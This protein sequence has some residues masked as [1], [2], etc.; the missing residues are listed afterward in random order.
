MATELDGANYS[1]VDASNNNA[2]PNGMPEGMSPSGVNDAGRQLMGAVK[3]AFDRDHA[4]TWC[5]VGGTANALTLAYTTG[6]LSY[7][8]GQKFAFLATAANT[9]AT[10]VNVSGLGIKNIF[11]AGAALAGAEIQNASIVEIEYDGTQFQLL[12]PGFQRIVMGFGTGVAATSGS[13][14]FL[15][16][17][18]IASLEGS[19][20][21][22]FPMPAGTVRAMYAACSAAPGIGQSSVVTLKLN[23]ANTS[24][25]C[26]ISGSG[27]VIGHD[28]AHT[29]ALVAG[30]LLDISLTPT[31]GAISASYMVTLFISV[32]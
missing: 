25:T 30:D 1:E 12:Q 24:V 2:A 13:T 31:A 10:T 5:T 8:Q 7:I 11:L 29:Q 3:R 32:P 18:G 22:P 4:G 26:T 27:S 14:N 16:I 19:S 6:P 28:S 9:G 17:G 21:V 15:G 23:G 20:Q